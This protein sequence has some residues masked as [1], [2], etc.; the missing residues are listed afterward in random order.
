M[1]ILM[2]V[3]ILVE[4]KIELLTRNFFY[5]ILNL[6]YNHF[7]IAFYSQIVLQIQKMSQYH[8]WLNM[9]QNIVN[10]SLSCNF[11]LLFDAIW[12][13]FFLLLYIIL[14]RHIFISDFRM[15]YQNT[16]LLLH[17]KFQIID[18]YIYIYCIHNSS[19]VFWDIL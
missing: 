17:Y 5:L 15:S 19:K 9:I 6:M 14:Y 10:K 7:S 1:A 11:L 3:S 4:I 8:A 16:K 18:I 2:N 13:S 12:M